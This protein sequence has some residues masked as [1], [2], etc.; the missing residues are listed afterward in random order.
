MPRDDSMQG[1][2]REGGDHLAA[3]ICLSKLHT[4][5]I[6]KLS[7]NPVSPC[8]TS[9]IKEPAFNEMFLRVSCYSL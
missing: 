6:F 4:R 9:V 3:T 1:R 8:Q 7:L 5:F 2:V